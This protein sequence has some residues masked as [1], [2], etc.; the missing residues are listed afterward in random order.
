MDILLH[1]SFR[2]KRLFK[3]H[4][5]RVNSKIYFEHKF[6]STS[7]HFLFLFLLDDKNLEVS[8]C[9]CQSKDIFASYMSMTLP[10]SYWYSLTKVY[11]AK[12]EEIEVFYCVFA[13]QNIQKLCGPKL[14]CSTEWYSTSSTCMETFLMWRWFTNSSSSSV[15]RV[16]YMI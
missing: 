3:I 11:E 7:S 16:Y 13:T 4:T 10:G 9:V 14:P 5:V 15:N 8:F 12:R 1:A 2:C 6:P